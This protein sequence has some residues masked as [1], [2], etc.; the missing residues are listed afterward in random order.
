MKRLLKTHFCWKLAFHH[1]SWTTVE[2]I[3][4]THWWKQLLMRNK[5]W[6]RL[7]MCSG[8]LWKDGSAVISEYCTFVHLAFHHCSWTT[9]EKY[10][11]THWWKELL[12]R[13]G[14]WSRLCMCTGAVEL[15]E[16]VT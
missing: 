9:A 10:L 13:T 3:F 14:I 5:I 8:A 16:K 1:C 2:S 15:C 7:S 4:T 11:F 6:R 12:M